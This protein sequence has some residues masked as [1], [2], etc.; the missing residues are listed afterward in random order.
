MQDHNPVFCDAIEDQIPAMNPATNT[1]ALIAWDD[2]PGLWHVSQVNA[3]ARKLL[4]R[5][6]GANRIVLSDLVADCF[7]VSFCRDGEFDDHSAGR[8]IA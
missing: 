6:Q 8:L 3:T 1:V 2:W 5:T 7:Q 4:H